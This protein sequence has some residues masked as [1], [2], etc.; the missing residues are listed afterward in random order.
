MR[1]YSHATIV[2]I[3]I[4]ILSDLHHFCYATQNGYTKTKVGSRLKLDHCYKNL[5]TTNNS[6]Y[7]YSSQKTCLDVR[8]PYRTTIIPDYVPEIQSIEHI[9]NHLEKWKQFKYLPN[10]WRNLQALLCSM[11]I[12]LLDEDPTMT[13]AARVSR[14][15]VDSCNNLIN[16]Q[17]CKFIARHYGWHPIFNCSDNGIY[18]KN[19]S[20]ELR[21]FQYKPP[22][23]LSP[24]VPTND[25]DTWFK[26]VSGCTMH[27]KYPIL[28]SKDQ[29]NIKYLIR[30]LSISGFIVTLIAIIIMD[31]SNKMSQ[32]IGKC[33]LCQPLLYLGW[34]L[35]TI[36]GRDIACSLSGASLY[37]L[38]I[39]ANACVLSFILTYSSMIHFSI[40]YAY[41]GE[42]CHRE[43]TKEE[44]KN[45]NQAKVAQNN[46]SQALVAQDVI[47]QGSKA[48]DTVTKKETIVK[49]ISYYLPVILFVAVAF[50]GQIDGN[51]IYGICTV[52]Q[53]SII[54]KLL[55]VFALDFICTAYGNIYHVRTIYS[56]LKKDIVS[57][58]LNK[59][60][61]RILAIVILSSARLLLGIGNHLH[62]YYNRSIWEDSVDKYV[63]CKLN[64]H[65]DNNDY[66]IDMMNRQECE[67]DINYLAPLYYLELISTLGLGMVIA[68]WAYCDK[69]IRELKRKV[70][71]LLE[72]KEDKKKRYYFN[73]MERGAP[74]LN[75]PDTISLTAS[76]A[77]T[78]T[79]L[80]STRLSVA[81]R[82]C[83]W[84]SRNSSLRRFGQKVPEGPPDDFTMVNCAGGFDLT[85]ELLTIHKFLNVLPE[86]RKISEVNRGRE[87]SLEPPKFYFS[88]DG[89]QDKP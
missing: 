70:I 75:H 69:N 47:A 60:Y 80:H 59:N 18:A 50:L 38:P 20:N 71:D 65:L 82:V 48:R 51:G 73:L 74:N 16:N 83:S 35:Q 86:Y 21:D 64:P 46:W 28:D 63:S 13:R 14:P 37:G 32:V 78:S 61:S 10:C 40:W 23:C 41:M 12:P 1:E 89:A 6:Y 45:E 36:L 29:E 5:T 39:V 81:G 34:S 19:C 66:E 49:W 26:D 17:H 57:S 54:M 62:E 42:I 79:S 88:L 85:P 53:K 25:S 30:I 15:S 31:K 27:C 68:S 55:F 72:D 9:S 87:P 44:D 67:L 43:L 11:F 7:K 76:Q 22:E 8:L 84:M 24:L 2:S 77:K 3:F 56:I 33:I 52:G 58:S 4:L